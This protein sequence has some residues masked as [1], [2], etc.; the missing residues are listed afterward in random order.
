RNLMLRLARLE[1]VLTRATELR[2]PNHLAEYTYEVATDFNR[3]YEA[4]HIL[5]EP[6][7]DRQASWL[8]LVEVTLRVFELLLDLL[9]IPVPERM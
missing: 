3:F 2:A 8:A 1:D 4:C 9:A 7:P 6:D 5:T